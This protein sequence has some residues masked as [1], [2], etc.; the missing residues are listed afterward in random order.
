M[1]K[2]VRLLSVLV[3]IAVICSALFVLGACGPKEFTVTYHNWDGDEI[4]KEVVEKKGFA[5]GKVAGYALQ[6][7]V[8]D[9]DGN[10][11]ALDTPIEADTSLKGHYIVTTSWV[12]DTGNYTWRSA[13]TT[14]PSNWNY[15][16]YQAND[17]TYI[18]NYTSDSLYTFDYNDAGDAFQIVPSMAKEMPIDV[19][20]EYAE[21]FGYD[22]TDA[23]G[24]PIVGKA[25]KIVLKDNLKYD[26]G[27]AINAHSFVRSVKNLLNPQAANSRAGELY[28]TGDLKIIGAEAYVKQGSS[29]YE[30]AINHF[31]GI[32]AAHD[33]GD[34]FV[35]M[36]VIEN[37]FKVEWFG[38]TYAQVKNAGYFAGYFSIYAGE[39]DARA[40]TGEDFFTKWI[41]PEVAKMT[42]DNQTIKLE[43]TAEQ[44]AQMFEDYSNCDDWNPSADAELASI[45]SVE[46]T[47]PEFSFDDVG[48]FAE[49]GDD[50]SLVVVL[51]DEMENDFWLKY[52]LATSFFLVNNTIYESCISTDNGV[53]TNDYATSI[54]KYSGYGPYMLSEYVAD[55]SF[56]LVRNPHWHG[57]FEEELAGQYQTTAIQYTVVTDDEIRLNMFLAGQLEGY[58]L[59]EEDMAKYGASKYTYYDDS[60]STWFIGMNPDANN[61]A[62]TAKLAT[63]KT[64]GNTVIK[65]P[66]AIDEFRQAMSYSLDR[67]AFCLALSPTSSPAKAALSAMIVYD[68]E[69]GLSYR[70]TEEAKDAILAFWGLSDAWGEGKEY[71]TKDDAIDS[72]TGYDLAGAK[73]LFTTAYNNAVAEGYIP[74]GNNW[75][76]Q[77]CIGASNWGSSFYS[78]GYDFL[79]ANWVEAV[80]GT[81][82]E[83]HLTFTK[84]DSLGSPG[85]A[86]ALK[87]GS[88]DLLFGV[89][90]GGSTFDPYSM[91]QC[92]VRD[93]LAYDTF[94]NKSSVSVDIEID[95]QVLRASLA[96]WLGK[97]LFGDPIEAKVVGED[98]KVTDE[99]VE[100]NAGLSAD[101]SL[102]LKIL[103]ACEVA[104][105]KMW[106]MMP[107]MTDATASLKCMRVN[108]KTEDYILGLG[109]GG[110]AYYTYTM[111]D[112]E[113]AAF[114][115]Q[116]G[117]TL[118]YTVTE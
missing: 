13:P 73:V 44:F 74:E 60:E 117:G 70:S 116:Q 8:Y 61:L 51:I 17:A 100:V 42:E 80:K 11:F 55:N 106:N 91:L 86:N 84:S 76:I 90:W 79:E 65:Q 35:D 103:S 39:G 63:P 81:P 26:N 24:N 95:G 77:I 82:W 2:T 58:G 50:Y 97:C 3:A 75:E 88:I 34:I 27:E 87:S 115:Q 43:W 38:G 14:I 20:A 94:T 54:A 99:I 98:G 66:L 59:R 21:K 25:Y 5:S 15:H 49:E 32:T 53:Y 69:V 28:S 92:F 36:A 102:R 78:K 6:G 4:G 29:L 12:N 96:D 30:A 41:E 23:D 89:G 18:L 62:E 64:A 110:I 107:L 93:D 111:T 71:A 9:M 46:Y 112:E 56:K 31:D 109:R 113:F 1:K 85:F 22:A 83:G 33:A 67:A 48:F 108:Y 45:L 7:S 40:K 72:I 19:T 114:V 52:N 101:S 10:I 105:L 47:Y 104:C 68:P 118:D 57:Y 37:L 16:T